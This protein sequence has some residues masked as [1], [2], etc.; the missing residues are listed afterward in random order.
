MIEAIYCVSLSRLSERRN[1]MIDLL[2]PFENVFDIYFF[3]A[4]DW[5]DL[6]VEKFNEE[7]E[8]N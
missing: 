4:I 2:S 7:G 3:D 8:D 5:K 1:S 6:S